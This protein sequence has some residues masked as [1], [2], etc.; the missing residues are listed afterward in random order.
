M[1][2]TGRLNAQDLE[3]RDADLGAAY[4][5]KVDVWAAGVVAY[6]LLLGHAP[7]YMPDTAD[8]VALIREGTLPGFLGF[9]S[10]DCTDFLQAVSPQDMRLPIVIKISSC[11]SGLANRGS[12]HMR[13][14]F[15]M[16]LSH[17][18]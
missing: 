6:E 14:F 1:Q 3:V 9:L 11:S 18:F 4:D 13:F 12:L 8:T 7:F 15:A 2:V 5:E 10:D 17:C 16:T